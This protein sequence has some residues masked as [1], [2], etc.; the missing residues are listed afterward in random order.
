MTLKKVIHRKSAPNT[1]SKCKEICDEESMNYIKS[2]QIQCR[3]NRATKDPLVKSNEQWDMPR[4]VCSCGKPGSN[5]IS[6]DSCRATIK[7]SNCHPKL[8]KVLPGPLNSKFPLKGMGISGRGF[9]V[10]HCAEPHAANTLLRMTN[11]NVSHIVFGTAFRTE[12][13]TFRD[14]CL[15]CKAT[16]KQLK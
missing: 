4:V 2:L 5:I 14:Y 11:C 13:C 6:I 1:E 7:A 16:F 15:T 3:K 8:T 10:G 9:R 12:D